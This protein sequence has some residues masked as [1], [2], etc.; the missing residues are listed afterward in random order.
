MIKA[1]NH[2]ITEDETN[3]ERESLQQTGREHVEPQRL[4]RMINANN[5]FIAEDERRDERRP[6]EQMRENPIPF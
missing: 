1:N 6:M 4:Q 5:H 3:Y 2:F